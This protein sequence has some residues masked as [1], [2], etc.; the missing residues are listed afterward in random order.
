MS[1]DQTP[2]SAEP[3]RAR[4]KP[5]VVGTCRGIELIRP[6]GTPSRT[7]EFRRAAEKALAGGPDILTRILANS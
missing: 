2:S 6:E 3:K 1:V 5:W 7:E 4:R